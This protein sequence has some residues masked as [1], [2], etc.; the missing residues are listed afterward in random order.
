MKVGIIGLGRMGSGIAQRLLEAGH[1]VIGYDPGAQA[2]NGAQQLGVTTVPTLA[3]LARE[4]RI[5]WLMVP[6]GTPVDATINSLLPYL[7]SGDIVVDGGNSKFTDSIARA[8]M[9]AHHG[10][11]FLDCGTSGG[12]HGRELGFC[13]MVG[14]DELIYKKIQPLLVAI[15]APNAVSHVGPSGA[16]HYVKMV[17]NGIEYGLMQA[18]AEGF[19]LLK[20]GT[21]KDHKLD[22]HEISRV[23]NQGSIIRSWL[24]ELTHT[25][26]RK[27]QELNAISGEIE[28]GGTGLWTAQDARACQVPMPVLDASLEV[29]RWSRKTGGNFA[30]K[31]IAMMRHAFG[32]HAVKKV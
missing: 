24:L 5:I 2:V 3:D 16:G 32:G 22:L 29:R 12:V 20:E 7:Q 28:E 11:S 25:I 15:A 14:G 9:L 26:L 18:Y 19:E 13:L 17:H 30:T 23:W 27:D 31:L 1:E 8:N 21:F 6:V 4:T 10:V